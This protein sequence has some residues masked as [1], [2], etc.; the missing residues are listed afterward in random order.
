MS[1]ACI[2]ISFDRYISAPKR[3]MHNISSHWIYRRYEVFLSM[4]DVSS[5]FLEIG[6]ETM[7]SDSPVDAIQERF[8]FILKEVNYGCLDGLHAR[9]ICD[10]NLRLRFDW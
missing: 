1:G 10:A 9:L 4:K 3:V 7:M 6:S 5:C 8:T 2:I